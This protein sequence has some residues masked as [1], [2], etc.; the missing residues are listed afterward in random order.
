[1]LVV[2]DVKT[3]EI[4]RF[5]VVDGCM[6]LGLISLNSHEKIFDPDRALGYV[7]RVEGQLLSLVASYKHS[8]RYIPRKAYAHLKKPPFLARLSGGPAGARDTEWFVDQFSVKPLLSIGGLDLSRRNREKSSRMLRELTRD[9]QYGGRFFRIQETRESGSLAGFTISIR[10]NEIAQAMEGEYRN[11][12][13]RLVKSG[14]AILIQLDEFE[15]LDEILKWL[16]L[17]KDAKMGIPS[18]ILHVLD[19]KKWTSKIERL[20]EIPNAR[21]LTAGATVVSLSSLIGALRRKLGDRWSERMVFGTNYPETGVGDGIPEILSYLLSKN[22]DASPEDIQRILSGNILSL[23]PLRPPYLKYQDRNGG[24]VAEGH[25]GRPALQEL[26]RVIQILTSSRDYTL[27]SFNYL[28]DKESG[29]VDT[30]TY[31]LTLL[32]EQA[33]RATTLIVRENPN[34]NLEI[35]TWNPHFD[36]AGASKNPTDL[37]TLA[38]SYSRT[39]SVVF[40]SPIQLNSYVTALTRCLNIRRPQELLAALRYQLETGDIPR[41]YLCLADVNIDAL[42]STADKKLLAMSQRKGQ[43]WVARSLPS[44]DITPR[45]AV[46][47]EG[48]RRSLGLESGEEID[49]TEYQESITKVDRA[50]F[51]TK[52]QEDV[53]PGE[54][55]SYL[56]LQWNQIEETIR[57]LLLGQ[58]SKVYP[59]TARESLALELIRTNP[60]IKTG[61]IADLAKADIVATQPEFLRDVDVIICIALSKRMTVKDLKIEAPYSVSLKLKDILR[62][63]GSYSNLLDT[64]DVYSSRLQ[65]AVVSALLII[66]SLEENRS[67][68]RLGLCLAGERLRKFSIQHGEDI[69]DFVDFDRDLE[70]PEVKTALKLF[71]LDALQEERS[72]QAIANSY[73]AI[74]EYADDFGLSRPTLAIL[75][76]DSLESPDDAAQGFIDVLPSHECFE[77]LRLGT[78]GSVESPK[79]ANRNT[80]SLDP[81]SVQRLIGELA[82][83]LRALDKN[84][85]S[86]K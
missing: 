50:I 76:G 45:T 66:E 52:A 62:G 73:R 17:L 33:R 4:Y 16:I 44:S 19:H 15:E 22:L 86:S 38:K 6:Q 78:Q 35:C 25:L 51:V 56:H 43:W 74:G 28:Y 54:M 12:I 34:S 65:G 26:Q 31:V 14:G 49:L 47:S 32:D 69:H 2:E 41:G 71:V 64:S 13:L 29:T 55:A 24:V 3:R 40:D 46:I 67:E 70:S 58:G 77:L 85:S 81:L 63:L 79:T 5:L 21:I 1:M 37:K 57:P 83:S 68:G 23:I 11:D 39:S 80:V 10:A 75:I 36:V 30:S 82:S 48:D 27:E 84:Q 42:G 20:V 53:D 7:S 60:P 61:E 72:D 9:G 8:Y 59:F 18:V